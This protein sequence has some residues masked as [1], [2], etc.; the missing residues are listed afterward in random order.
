MKFKAIDL[1]KKIT[2]KVQFTI[3]A[4]FRCKVLMR[5]KKIN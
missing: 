5:T 3:T 2:L 1:K 4:D